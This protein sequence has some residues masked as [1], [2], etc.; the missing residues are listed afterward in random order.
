MV[1]EMT[2]DEFV[3]WLKGFIDG[4]GMQLSQ[5]QAIDVYNKSID[6]IQRRKIARDGQ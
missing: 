2:S 3:V 5:T 4:S 6:V 1:K